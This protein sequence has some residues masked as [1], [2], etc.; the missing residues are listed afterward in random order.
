MLLSYSDLSKL[1]LNTFYIIF[2]TINN[3]IFH[4]TLISK[5]IV[6]AGCCWLLP[7]ACSTLI[8]V[9]I[10][11][12]NRNNLFLLL[13]YTFKQFLRVLLFPFAVRMH[14]S[15]LVHMQREHRRRQHIKSNICSRSPWN[16]YHTQ[17]FHLFK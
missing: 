6:A 14:I 15:S 8:V 16:W 2:S 11:N 3:L 1:F 10:I 5:K 9:S 12:T 4:C 7:I 13:N 17:E